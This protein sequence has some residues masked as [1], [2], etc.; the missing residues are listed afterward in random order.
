[1]L[2]WVVFLNSYHDI[3]YETYVYG[4]KDLFEVAFELA[5]ERDSFF[6]GPVLPRLA[7]T[8]E[9]LLVSLLLRPQIASLV[10]TIGR[11]MDKRYSTPI[12][13]AQWGTVLCDLLHIS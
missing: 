3:L 7:L 10:W 5:G 4:D 2:H 11:G 8:D 9:K 13:A 1:M 6:R 12:L